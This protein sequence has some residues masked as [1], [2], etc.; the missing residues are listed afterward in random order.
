[1][2]DWLRTSADG[3]FAAGDVCTLLS[4]QEKPHWQQ[5]KK[6]CGKN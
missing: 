4:A 5:V 3:V 6:R 1:M 2:D